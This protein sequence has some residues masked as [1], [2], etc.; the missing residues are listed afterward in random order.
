MRTI[1]CLGC[2]YLYIRELRDLVEFMCCWYKFNK[3]TKG[4][5]GTGKLIKISRLKKCPIL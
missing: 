2:D 5:E 1:E 4:R 3:G